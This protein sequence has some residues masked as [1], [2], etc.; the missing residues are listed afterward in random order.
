MRW[1]YIKASNLQKPMLFFCIKKKKSKN[2]VR[3]SHVLTIGMLDTSR[4]VTQFNALWS[5][6]F[7]K[8]VNMQP[9]VHTL[10]S[11]VHTLHYTVYTLQSTLYNLHTTLPTLHSKPY[12]LHSQTTLSTL[13]CRTY[14]EG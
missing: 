6:N 8:T 5:H 4:I 7:A 1:V 9:R 3:V 10:H 2:D 14:S 13:Y 11:T 12:I